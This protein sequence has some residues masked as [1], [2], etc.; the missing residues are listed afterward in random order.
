M[1]SWTA[2]RSRVGVALR[3]L[4]WW[5][6]VAVAVV[7]H[8][9]FV[10]GLLGD[11]PPGWLNTAWQVSG[12]LVG[13]GVALVVFLLQAAGSQSL[14]S[15]ATYR[16]LLA[17]TGL[18]WPATLALVFLISV[19]VLERYGATEGGASGWADTWALAVFVIQVVAFG[20]AFAPTSGVV[21]PS[22]VARVLRE[23]FEDAMRAGVESSLL[24]RVMVVDLREL[25]QD[26]VSFRVFWARGEP[27]LPTRPG[28]L[29]DVDRRSPGLGHTKLGYRRHPGVGNRASRSVP[30]IRSPRWKGRGAT[31]LRHDPPW[32]GASS[33]RARD[34]AG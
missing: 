21:S 8:L 22:G 9:P 2:W 32:R 3:Q 33:D 14:S 1:D 13:L 29:T 6:P 30:R 24:R 18:I 16:A 4:N 31:G 10:I 28:V 12:T 7:L 20:V 25:A 19:G 27:G 11:P 34:V 23:T 15:E 5:P 26:R 17:H